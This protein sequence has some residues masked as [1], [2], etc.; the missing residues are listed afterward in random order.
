MARKVIPLRQYIEAWD[1][2]YEVIDSISKETNMLHEKITFREV[3]KYFETTYK[4]HFVYLDRDPFPDLPSPGL[5]GSEH[6]KHRGLVT[7]PDVT[8]SPD[9]ISKHNDGMTIFDKSQHKYVVFINQRHIKE[10]VIFTILHELAHIKAHFDTGR[11]SEIALACAGNY[12]DNPLEL[13]ANAIASLF[14]INNARM[15]WHLKSTHSYQDI[16]KLNA[17]SD[18][19]LFNRLVDF[20][21]YRIFTY[22]EY[23]LDE[24]QRRRAAIDLVTKFKKGDLTLFEY[25][26]VNV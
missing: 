18:N 17:I 4:I 1:Y 20:V 15:V 14:Y 9:I 8:F 21:Q 2:A 13:E 26:D 3:I 7:N 24:Q 25:Y 12:K 16:K 11:T 6:I 19:A 23:L 22:E 10:R 5:L